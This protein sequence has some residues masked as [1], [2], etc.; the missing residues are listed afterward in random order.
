MEILLKPLGGGIFEGVGTS[1]YTDLVL[2]GEQNMMVSK[3]VD[4]EFVQIAQ[5]GLPY[6]GCSDHYYRKFIG[7]TFKSVTCG[8][9]TH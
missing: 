7:Y 9:K 8:D 5:D 2:S 4:G 1:V 3:S 6:K